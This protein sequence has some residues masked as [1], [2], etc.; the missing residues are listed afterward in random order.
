MSHDELSALHDAIHALELRL[1]KLETTF[2]IGGALIG[3]ASL[4]VQ[5]WAVFHA[6]R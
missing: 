3:V 5:I 1:V 4:A 2:K 6:T